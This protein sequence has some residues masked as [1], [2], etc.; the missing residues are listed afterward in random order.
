MNISNRKNLIFDFDGTIVDSLD[1]LV[2]IYNQICYKYGCLQVDIKDKENLKKLKSQEILKTYKISFFKIPFLLIEVKK[3][4]K[5]RISEIKM[6]NDLSF[7]LQELKSRGFSLYILTSNS[8]KNVEIFLEDNNLLNIF[9]SVY[10]SSNV[11]G[12]DRSMERFLQDNNINKNDCIYIG[13]E[14]RDIE[15]MKRVDVPIVSVGWGFNSRE[16]LLKMEPNEIID[17][18]NNLLSLF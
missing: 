16:A 3:K 5:K 1:L 6:F 10:S 15:A 14:T 7:V 17:K 9:N 2:Q 12:K 11:F 18:P 4:F 13:D 8:K